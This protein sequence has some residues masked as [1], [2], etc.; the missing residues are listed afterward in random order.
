MIDRL[1]TLRKKGIKLITQVRNG[2]QC[3]SM[4]LP[5]FMTGEERRAGEVAAFYFH[6][7]LPSRFCLVVDGSETRK[8]VNLLLSLGMSPRFKERLE[9][10]GIFSKA[11]KFWLSGREIYDEGFGFV[12][13]LEDRYQKTSELCMDRWSSRP[14]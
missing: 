6:G 7:V 13:T 14:R 11:D 12:T 8:Y 4:C 5:I 1:L 2:D 10:D 3:G 9:R